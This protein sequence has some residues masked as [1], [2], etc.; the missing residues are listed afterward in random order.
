MEA[1]DQ[2]SICTGKP[3]NE[4]IG[5]NPRRLLDESC[6]EDFRRELKNAWVGMVRDFS[7]SLIL[8][9]NGTGR[10]EVKM[11]RITPNSRRALL[12]ILR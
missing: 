2:V 8:P 11:T 7:V 9:Q 1:T 3:R 5:S 4:L 10:F 12:V 6:R